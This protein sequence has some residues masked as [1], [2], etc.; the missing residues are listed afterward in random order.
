MK[1][2]AQGNEQ[3]ATILHM[4]GTSPDSARPYRKCYVV[5]TLTT[6]TTQSGSKEIPAPQDTESQWALCF[7]VGFVLGIITAALA[8]HIADTARIQ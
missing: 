1:A 6:H 8:R 4:N 5:D 3:I 2:L 7:F